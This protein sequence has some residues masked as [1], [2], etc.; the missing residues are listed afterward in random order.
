M[1]TTESLR[2]PAASVLMHTADRGPISTSKVF[3]SVLAREYGAER[4]AP[5]RGQRLYLHLSDL[6]MCLSRFGS[7]AR[8]KV[9]DFGCGQS[10]YR[11]L[12]PNADYRRA[13]AI[14]APDLDYRV[15]ADESIAEESGLFDVILSTQVRRACRGSGPLP[16]RM[17]P[18]AWSRWPPDHQH[19]RHLRGSWTAL[20]LP[21]V[22]C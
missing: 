18:T 12:F 3:E 15:G 11:S 7:E 16:V 8:L 14:D 20:R 4:T 13:D 6:A 1:R 22:D 21:P 19:A 17:L 2:R 9:L 5:Q 10:P